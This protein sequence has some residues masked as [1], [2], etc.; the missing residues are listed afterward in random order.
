MQIARTIKEVSRPPHGAGPVALVPT[1][2]CLHE[3]H[4]SLVRR[5]RAESNRVVVSIF[6]NPT[7]FGPSE[8]FGKYP[9]DEARDIALL[10]HEGVD[11]V[12]LPKVD[13]IFPPGFNRWVDVEG[14]LGQRLEG[15]CRPGHFRGVAT[16]VSRL[17]EIVQPDRAYFGQKD[18]QQLLVVRKLV[19]DM[20]L[21]IEIVGCPIVRESD[22]LAMSSRNVYLSPSERQVALSLPRALSLAAR[23]VEFERERD[24]QVVIDCAA[25]VLYREPALCL[26]YLAVADATTLSDIALLDRPALLLAAVRIGATRLIDNWLL[27]PE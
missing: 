22:G 16:A 17:L 5:A 18:A 13:E 20:G 1:M 3:G 24:P 14:P 25:E 10:E 7:Q 19:S 8:D 15:A 12:F 27:S 4:L 23:L 21:A 9:R 6:V 11:V 2:G 26:E